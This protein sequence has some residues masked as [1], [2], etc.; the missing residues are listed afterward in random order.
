GSSAAL[1]VAVAR[2]AGAAAG[3]PLSDEQAAEAAF[4]GER[5][6]HGNPSGVD[7][8]VAAFGGLLWYRRPGGRRRVRLPAPLRLVI[9]HSGESGETAA[10][11]AGVRE[12]YER[13]PQRYEGL[14]DEMG[15]LV[16]EALEAIAHSRLA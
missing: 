3:R 15:S 13:D 2:A 4:A 7:N 14:F 12:R 16:D 10:Q 5:C 1:C 9:G 11:V 6:F 8:T